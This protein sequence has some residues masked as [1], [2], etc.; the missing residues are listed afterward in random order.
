MSQNLTVEN[1]EKKPETKHGKY[2]SP[3]SRWWFA[4]AHPVNENLK[5]DEVFE[6]EIGGYQWY[7]AYWEKGEE[8]NRIH[9]HFLVY[10]QNQLTKGNDL[11]FDKRLKGIHWEL[12]KTS[13]VLKVRNY[14]YFKYKDDKTQVPKNHIA[15]F[16][17]KT[18]KPAALTQNIRFMAKEAIMNNNCEFFNNLTKEERTDI[19]EIN[20][21]KFHENRRIINDAKINLHEVRDASIEIRYGQSRAGKSYGYQCADNVCVIDQ[22]ALNPHGDV[23]FDAADGMDHPTTFVFNE[24]GCKTLSITNALSLVDNTAVRRPIKGDSMK[25]DCRLLVFIFNDPI[26][27]FFDYQKEGAKVDAFQERISLV[28]YYY[29]KWSKEDPKTFVDVTDLYKTFCT[30]VH[31]IYTDRKNINKDV[32]FAKVADEY[33]IAVKKRVESDKLEKR[34]NKR[35]VK[36]D[37]EEESDNVLNLDIDEINPGCLSD[38]NKRFCLK[39]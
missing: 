29:K 18:N 27:Q 21:K 6:P 22:T 5:E 14:E 1:N 16:E 8:N 23:W 39:K 25:I 13:E 11:C 9:V 32:S 20:L 12:V 33:E 30:K 17:S 24:F 4:T 35:Q 7:R 37:D 31:A 15:S 36:V 28:R 19:G 38:I 10:T 34:L 3:R 26:V 2:K